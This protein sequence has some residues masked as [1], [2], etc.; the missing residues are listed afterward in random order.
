MEGSGDGGDTETPSD[1]HEE[2]CTWNLT[3]RKWKVCGGG[4]VEN[5]LPLHK[6]TLQHVQRCFCDIRTYEVRVHVCARAPPSLRMRH[7]DDTTPS[8]ATKPSHKSTHSCTHSNCVYPRHRVLRTHCGM[9]EGRSTMTPSSW[10]CPSS[11]PRMW[12]SLR[13]CVE[14]VYQY[15]YSSGL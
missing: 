3:E 11:H 15:S 9:T 7:V 1:P 14:G 2:L 8:N 5:S 4:G 6:T 12:P 10:S 13:V